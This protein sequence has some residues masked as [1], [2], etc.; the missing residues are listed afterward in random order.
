MY[1]SWLTLPVHNILAGIQGQSPVEQ[2]RLVVPTTDD[3]T[4]PTLT[5]RVWVVGIIGC[6]ILSFVSVLTCFRQNPVDIPGFVIILVC[7]SLGNLMAS[8]L[9]TKLVR[10]PR[11]KIMFSLNPGPFSIKEHILCVTIFSSGSGVPIATEVLAVTRYYFRRSIHPAAYF[12]LLFTT[13]VSNKP[14]TEVVNIN[15]NFY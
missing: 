11:T 1:Y 6:I 3:P 13:A 15:Y 10:V 12:L 5:F 7:Y 8:M 9:P 14:C 4:L 2:L